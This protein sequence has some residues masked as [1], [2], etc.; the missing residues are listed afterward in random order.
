MTHSVSSRTVADE[1][2]IVIDQP[3]CPGSLSRIAAHQLTDDEISIDCEHAAVS[4][5]RRSPPPNPRSTLPAPY[6][7]DPIRLSAGGRSCL[8]E[9]VAA[10]AAELPESYRLAAL[11]D[12][13]SLGQE[14]TKNT[15]EADPCTFNQPI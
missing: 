5:R 12:F 7:K 9:S 1:D 11:P 4:P 8:P 3:A 2:V 10:R 15:R 14:R 13:G 6:R